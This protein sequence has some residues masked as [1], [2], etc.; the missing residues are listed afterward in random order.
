MK[1]R[2]L[3]SWPLLLLLVIQTTP[4]TA[5]GQARSHFETAPPRVMQICI[6]LACQTLTWRGD[7]Y[8]AADASGVVG[9]AFKVVRWDARSIMLTGT[10]LRPDNDGHI[11]TGVFTA[12]IAPGGDQTVNGKNAWQAGPF[13]GVF[14]VTF[15][16]GSEAN[17]RRKAILVRLTQPYTDTGLMVTAGET[18]SI[19]ARGA[20]TWYTGGCQFAACTVLTP[21]GISCP[22]NRGD[23]APG[24]P[25]FSLIGK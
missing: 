12:D 3:L 23:T 1:P 22:V 11:A 16:W 15:S 10:T 14:D 25:C 5:I 19:K 8:D 2:R 21:A 24:L 6:Q 20:M 4:E 18:V 9:A 7:H 13:H 17:V